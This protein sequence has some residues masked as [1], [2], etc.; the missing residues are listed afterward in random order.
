MDLFFLDFET[1]GL[2]PYLNHIIEVAIKKYEVDTPYQTLIKPERLPPGIVRYIPPHITNLT[3][4]TDTMIEKDSIDEKNALYNMFQYIEKYSKKEGPIYIVAHNGTT[5]DFIIFRRLIHK[6]IKEKNFTRFQKLLLN[7][8]KY[9]D[10]LLL[11]RYFLSDRERVTDNFLV[12][13]CV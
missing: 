12:F 2:N 13:P 3:K 10:T 5:F 11:A 7:R 6:Y 4:I 9:I 1:T 8:F